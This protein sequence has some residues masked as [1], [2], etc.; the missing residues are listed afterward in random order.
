M[1][2]KKIKRFANTVYS[3]VVSR[4][5]NRNQHDKICKIQD[6]WLAFLLILLHF[7]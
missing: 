3:F 4:D 5:N 2:K 1:G 7:G 6:N